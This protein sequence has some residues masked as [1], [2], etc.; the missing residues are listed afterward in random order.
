MN[1]LALDEVVSS[2]VVNSQ[3]VLLS[4]KLVP[5]I[6][7]TEIDLYLNNGLKMV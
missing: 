3:L 7:T 4:A 2:L 6:I 5:G 1:R